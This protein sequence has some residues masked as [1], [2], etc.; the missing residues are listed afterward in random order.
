MGGRFNLDDYVSVA[1][2]IQILYDR[3]PDASIQTR[4]VE[5]DGASI[6]I[7][8]RVYK[9]REDVV[10]GVFTSG[11]AHE[12]DGEGNVN[13]TSHV[14]NAETSACGRALA[15]L[16]FAVKVGEQRP[17]R[18]EMEKVERVEAQHSLD[19]ERISAFVEADEDVDVT[20]K[21]KETSLI[22]LIKKNSAAIKEQPSKAA[23]IV[24]MIDA[25]NADEDDESDPEVEDDE[26]A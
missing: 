5:N 6:I 21:G 18:E 8:A 10:D 20:V 24:R 12:R 22:A 14:E 2:R 19:L 3:Y 23:D 13:K 17:S 9:S 16:G 25:A 11:L 7:E 1:E 26:D 4:V 15:N